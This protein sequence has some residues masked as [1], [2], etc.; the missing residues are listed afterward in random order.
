MELK[1]QLEYINQLEVQI[2]NLSLALEESKT[3]L[4]AIQKVRKPAISNAERHKAHQNRVDYYAL[5]QQI[6]DLEHA[7]RTLKKCIDAVK[8]ESNSYSLEP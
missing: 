8:I 4:D 5:N 6:A 2:R 3:A 7:I 1:K